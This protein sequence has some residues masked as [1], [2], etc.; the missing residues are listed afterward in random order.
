MKL[1]RPDP[2][3]HLLKHLPE[4]AVRVRGNIALRVEDEHGLAQEDETKVRAFNRYDAGLYLLTRKG[5]LLT[6]TPQHGPEITVPYSPL[7]VHGSSVHTTYHGHNT[8]IVFA[9]V[10]N[11]GTEYLAAA[12]TVKEK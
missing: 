3:E 11:L 8:E 6:I 9:K 5:Y 7:R 1:G 10:H 4:R 2:T 12:Q